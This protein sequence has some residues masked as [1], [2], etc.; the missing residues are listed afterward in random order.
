[1]TSNTDTSLHT[2]GASDTALDTDS[3]IS[4]TCAMTEVLKK[5][6]NANS[7]AKS[8]SAGSDKKEQMAKLKRNS[9]SIAGIGMSDLESRSLDIDGERLPTKND[10]EKKKKGKK[11]KSKSGGSE[12]KKQMA[13][14]LRNSKVDSSFL[15]EF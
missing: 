9:K 15:D 1:M 2:L 8:N 7:K 10:V 5:V 6:K 3:M 12:T 14:L 4:K 13:K 11:G